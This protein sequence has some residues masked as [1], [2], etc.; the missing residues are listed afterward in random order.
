VQLPPPVHG[1]SE[2]NRLV[3]E[4]PLIRDNYQTEIVQIRFSE[5]LEGLRRYNFRK[6][7]S[8]F[9]IHCQLKNKLKEFK[10]DLVYFSFIPIGIGFFRDYFFLRLIRKYCSNILIHLNNRGIFERSHKLLYRK[11]YLTTFRNINII[12]VSKGLMQREFQHLST[13]GMK[14]FVL[15][16][17]CEPFQVKSI[18]GKDGI[19]NILFF[20]NLFP[21]KGIFIA[22]EAFRG[23]CK[24][25]PFVHLHIYGQPMRER[26]S[27]HIK[28]YIQNNNLSD[29]VHFHGSADLHLKIHAFELADIFIFP[30]YFDEE[31]MPLCI[32]EAMQAGL[33]IIASRIGAVPEMI[34]D[35]KDGILI[36]P[37]KT[38]EL[39]LK[40]HMLITNRVLRE[41]L[42]KA[43]RNVFLENY[44]CRE[45]NY[46]FFR[47]IQD[48]LTAN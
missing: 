18:G 37:G 10:P 47:I 38:Q 15:N 8:F 14:K 23:L 25:F 2:T 22:L 45:F 1:V 26:Y 34:I 16:N 35:G 19:F 13:P 5:N 46:K 36:E 44:S 6:I 43:A 24:I 27:Q 11:L 32:L 7:S 20:S 29:K 48:I 4:N 39:I 41:N 42:S 31:C 12:H 40:M 21:Q 17:T 33:P 28:R 30:S 9:K 3:V